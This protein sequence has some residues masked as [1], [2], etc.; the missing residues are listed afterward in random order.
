MDIVIIIYEPK[1][2]SDDGV[3]TLW[4]P[5]NTVRFDLLPI[6]SNL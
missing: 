2:L 5:E 1:F 4:V 6:N 3:A